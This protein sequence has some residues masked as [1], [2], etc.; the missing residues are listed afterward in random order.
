MPVPGSDG[1]TRQLIDVA[2]IAVLESTLKKQGRDASVLW[3]SPENW[4][5]IGLHSIAGSRTPA[6]PSLTPSFASASLIDFEAVVI[7]GWIP[8]EVRARL[9]AAV[10]RNARTLDVE[11][12]TLPEIREGTVGIHARALGA[13]SLPLSGRFLLGQTLIPANL[14]QT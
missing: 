8:L 13:A 6:R 11:G 7:D 12:I 2:S 10:R 5:G 1:R 14:G 4:G 3:A 9:V